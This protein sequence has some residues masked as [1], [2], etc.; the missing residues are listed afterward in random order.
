[1]KYVVHANLLQ[2]SFAITSEHLLIVCNVHII[3][4]DELK[5]QLRNQ[6]QLQYIWTSFYPYSPYLGITDLTLTHI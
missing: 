1:M 3:T 4:V 6:S 2:S 5:Y